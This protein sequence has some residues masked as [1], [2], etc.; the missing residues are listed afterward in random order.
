MTKDW[1]QLRGSCSNSVYIMT[2][3]VTV[4]NSCVIF[5]LSIWWSD[6]NIKYSQGKVC[7]SQTCTHD[8]VWER[9]ESEMS[10]KDYEYNI[11]SGQKR[12]NHVYER[13]LIYKHGCSN[14]HTHTHVICNFQYK[15]ITCVD[16]SRQEMEMIGN[17]SWDGDCRQYETPQRIFCS[18]IPA[19]VQPVLPLL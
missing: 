19:A 2:P 10:Q 15:M 5:H 9:G 18:R 11:D 3:K 6:D 17:I 1:R 7:I 13:D 4:A 14:A 8:S 12:P 16:T